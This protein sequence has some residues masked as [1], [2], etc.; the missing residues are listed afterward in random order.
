MLVKAKTGSGKTAAYAI[1]VLQKLLTSKR[2]AGGCVA[3]HRLY[4][5]VT[6]MVAYHSFA[7]LACVTCRRRSSSDPDPDQRTVP[8]DC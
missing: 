7:M 4:F 8:S 2:V 6:M 1:P 3:M 5:L